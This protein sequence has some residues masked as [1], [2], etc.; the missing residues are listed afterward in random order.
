MSP[1]LLN[2]SQASLLLQHHRLLAHRPPRMLHNHMAK[3]LLGT[4]SHNPHHSTMVSRRTEH[5]QGRSRQVSL[6]PS[7]PFHPHSHTARAIL[8]LL[9]LLLLSMPT[10]HTRRVRLSTRT[11]AMLLP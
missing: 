3:P 1:L 9:F 10:R 8:R 4:D 7:H 11:L 2:T 6:V 5:L